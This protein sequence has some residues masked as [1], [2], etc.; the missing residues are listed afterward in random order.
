VTDNPYNRKRLW[1][2]G[3]MPRAAAQF[4]SKRVRDLAIRPEQL[5]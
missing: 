2:R 1:W 3:V 5:L 4:I